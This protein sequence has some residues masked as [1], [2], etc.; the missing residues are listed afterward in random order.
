MK[1]EES[2][3]LQ[4]LES[5]IAQTDELNS[6][7]AKLDVE[8]DIDR[9]L[10]LRQ[11]AIEK[12]DDVMG[13]MKDA[14]LATFLDLHRDKIKNLRERDSECV[15]LMRGRIA[16]A[17]DRMESIDKGQQ[18]LKAYGDGFVGKGRP[19]FMDEKG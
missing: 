15:S 5:F 14:S 17:R 13:S 18:A 16:A 2:R 12:M 4:L 3:L 7:L 8:L 9:I 19:R 10:T 11:A 6:V 1:D